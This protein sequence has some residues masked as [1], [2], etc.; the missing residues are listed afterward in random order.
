VIIASYVFG[1]RRNRERFVVEVESEFAV[2]SHRWGTKGEKEILRGSECDALLRFADLIVENTGAALCVGCTRNPSRDESAPDVQ[3]P[4][5]GLPEDAPTV[6]D[7]GAAMNRL[8]GT[9]PADG[10]GNVSTPTIDPLN[11]I[12]P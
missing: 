3:D 10:T 4:S 12:R 9:K 6:W 7:A 1:P 2:L 8:T 5:E 11:P